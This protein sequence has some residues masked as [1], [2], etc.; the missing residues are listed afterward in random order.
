MLKQD[1]MRRLGA[2]ICHVHPLKFLETIFI[3]PR[4]RR[5]VPLILDDTFKRSAFM[6]GLGESMTRESQKGTLEKY[7]PEFIAKI[8]GT[9]ELKGLQPFC[10]SRDWDGFINYLVEHT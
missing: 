3:N 9:T 6:D 2:Q 4:L 5:C 7:L 1:T 10:K 8:G